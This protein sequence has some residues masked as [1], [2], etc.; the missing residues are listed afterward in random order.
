[1][2]LIKGPP[3]NRP[4][5]AS[6]M[7]VKNH[8]ISGYSQG[9]GEQH[10]HSRQELAERITH[11]LKSRVSTSGSHKGSST[12]Y[13]HASAPPPSIPPLTPNTAVP[14]PPPFNSC[15]SNEGSFEL[16]QFAG[17]LFEQTYR[18]R[19]SHASTLERS[20]KESARPKHVPED[21]GQNTR[22]ADPASDPNLQSHI[23][24]LSNLFSMIEDETENE[25]ETE[26][27]R[28]L[29]FTP[30]TDLEMTECMEIEP[31]MLREIGFMP[32]T[33]SLMTEFLESV[34]PFPGVAF[35]VRACPGVKK[36]KW[37]GHGIRS[38][39]SEGQGMML[40]NWY[41]LQLRS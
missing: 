39:F 9:R 28:D 31:E 11:Q 15:G 27:R 25:V 40:L 4:R 8:G 37:P 29:G 13:D 10:I 41:S 5:L 6:I 19:S 33:N 38:V 24:D 30:V 26:M 17:T 18:Q 21:L 3:C 16:S 34:I 12:T 14:S 32:V 36:K 35:I 20:R 1:M 23:A 7:P 2:L 22:P